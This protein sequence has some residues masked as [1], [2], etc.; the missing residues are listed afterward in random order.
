MTYM[1]EEQ[2]KDNHHIGFLSTQRGDFL[3]RLKQYIRNAEELI[4]ST[5]FISVYGLE[6][7][8][9]E[10]HYVDKI[11]I[12][13]GVVDKQAD[14]LVKILLDDTI[15]SANKFG[16][17]DTYSAIRKL[18]YSGRLEVAF[19]KNMIG[20]RIF[21]AKGYLFKLRGDLG[22]FFICGS[23]NFTGGGLKYNREWALETSHMPT[24]LAAKRSFELE[25]HINLQETSRLLEG[26]YE[27]YISEAETGVNS[28]GNSF[29]ELLLKIES[30][31]GM[32]YLPYK[33]APK[34][35]MKSPLVEGFSLSDIESLSTKTNAHYD[36]FNSVDEW[37]THVVDCTVTVKIQRTNEK[38]IV[39]LQ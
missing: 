28:K 22:V 18:Y 34:K 24:Y 7:V 6:A 36:E 9:E 15:I 37:L 25:W 19:R 12:L 11:Q 5:G 31:E 16:T 8:L 14:W 30:S 17:T 29:I 35:H 20:I 1:D 4:I 13:I 27:A 32:F 39:L 10:L 38:T 2:H 26:E 23:N 3:F 33:I 21:H